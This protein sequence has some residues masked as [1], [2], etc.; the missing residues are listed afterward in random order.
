MFPDALCTAIAGMTPVEQ[1]ISEKRC[2]FSGLP[3]LSGGAVLLAWWCALAEAAQ[4][5]DN[6]VRALKLIEAAQTVTVRMRLNPSVKQ[7]LLD[8]LSWSEIARTVAAACGDSLLDIVLKCLGIP[9][10]E[11]AK[12]LQK[13]TAGV[14]WMR[15][16]R[17]QQAH[18]RGVRPAGR[19]DDAVRSRPCL[20]RGVRRPA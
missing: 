20:L 15:A 9:E 14:N 11:S 8:S 17:S 2:R 6:K 10:V 4:A 19:G 12:T 3:C 13:N 7:I 16:Y 5:G 1:N 18:L